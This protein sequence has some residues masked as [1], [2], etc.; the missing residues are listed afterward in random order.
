MM[1]INFNQLLENY[2]QDLLND[3]RGFG[4]NN[5]YLKYWVPGTDDFKSFLNLI[6]ALVEVNI[7]KF[8]IKFDGKKVDL[9][10]IKNF[11]KITSDFKEEQI[12]KENSIILNIEINKLRYDTHKKKNLIKR[13]ERKY[14]INDATKSVSF[15]KPQEDIIEIYK[16]NINQIDYNEYKSVDKLSGNNI[17]EGTIDDLSLKF[18]I[19]NSI[20]KKL[21]HSGS[22]NMILSKVV[23]IFCDVIIKKN[24][25]EASE[26]GV[27]FLEEKI[28]SVSNNNNI[29]G[30]ILP[31]QAGRYF[32]VLNNMIRSIEKQY[33]LQ[34]SQRS[35]INKDYFR[36]SE[37]W[38]NLDLNEK[39][40]K[41]MGIINEE[42]VNKKIISEESIK[43]NK[44]ESNFKIFFDINKDFREVQS[45]KNI[46]L[47]LEKKLKKLDNTLEV[48]VEEIIDQNKL[49]LKNSPQNI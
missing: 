13:D 23:N 34:N 8:K 15:F 48:F 16:R 35:E 41:I 17:F 30:I 49:R 47:E 14:E 32:L 43:I 26:H 4:K 21:I 18:K 7:L 12:E 5:E 28:R 9:E 19:E 42:F 3:L 29:N 31:H 45:K 36:I 39:K 40:I 46:L 2:D 27:I 10:K 44:I 24:I 6:D 20:I 11:M 33:Y 1:E 22:S 37:N 25:Q 38:K